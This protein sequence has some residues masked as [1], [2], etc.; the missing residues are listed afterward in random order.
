MSVLKVETGACSKAGQKAVNQDAY[1]FH[2]P[3]A[4]LLA[5]KGV[6]AAIADG[7]SSSTVSAQASVTAVERFIADYYSTPQEWSVKHAAQQVLMAVNSLLNA[8]TF[9]SVYR[10]DKNQG[11]VCTFSALV[12]KSRTVHLFHVGDTRIYRLR[13]GVL[14]A[15]TEDHRFWV[16]EE[17]SY[18]ARALGMSPN[19]DLDYL[20]EPVQAGDEYLLLSDGVYE[21]LQEADY[22]ATLASATTLDSACE[23]WVALAQQRGSP[24]NLTALALRVT[25]LPEHEMDTFYGEMR[26]LPFPPELHTGMTLDDFMILRLL[27]HSQRSQLWLARDMT[28]DARVVIKIPGTEIRADQEALSHFLLE[29]WIGRRVQHQH[30]ARPYN[31]LNPRHY[32]YGCMHYVEGSTLHQWMLDHPQPSLETVRLIVEQLANALEA[33]H[34]LEMC[35]QDLRP[36]NIMVDSDLRVTLVDFGSVSV[37]GLNELYGASSRQCALVTAA[38]SAPEY[39][40]GQPVTS[41]S[42]LY[43]LG[44]ITYQLL[45]GKLPYGTEVAKV[46]HTQDL[47]RLY[48]R[49]IRYA[50]PAFPAWVDAAIARAVHPQA[51]KRYG[52]PSEFIHDLRVP[53]PLLAQQAQMPLLQRNPV[54]FW[55]GLSTILALACLALAGLLAHQPAAP[56]TKTTETT[57]TARPDSNKME[58]GPVEPN[59]IN[60]GM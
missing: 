47:A 15:L 42:D 4:A 28:S 59:P 55:R 29:E 40:T 31:P 13:Q 37:A 41:R 3:A 11:Y 51:E 20:C 27:H 36:Q 60:P 33:F 45:T 19:P 18:L 25:A 16:S 26:T 1:G 22:L 48:Y 44:A 5:G 8:Q 54:L 21:F 52:S 58:S 57:S 17:Q 56:G 53:N 34:R 24:D 38:Y 35:Y 2:I 7:I 14:Q 46:R 39:W 6:T 10:F 23:Q 50:Q 49:E 30:I 9:R 32:L 12:I 43:A